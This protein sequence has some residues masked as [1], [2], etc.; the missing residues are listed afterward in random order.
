MNGKDAYFTLCN[1]NN[2]NVNYLLK[3][4]KD[5]TFTGLTVI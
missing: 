1:V 5:P 2:V 3:T 4:Y